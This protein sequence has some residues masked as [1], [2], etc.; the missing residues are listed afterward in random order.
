MYKISGVRYSAIHSNIPRVFCFEKRSKY[1]ECAE[2]RKI[3]YR[4]HVQSNGDVRLSAM[5]YTH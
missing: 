5:Q 4:Y 3:F 2:V 1:K